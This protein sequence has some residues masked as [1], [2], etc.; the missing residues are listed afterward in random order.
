[1]GN[2]KKAIPFAILALGA[3][4]AALGIWQ[5]EAADVWQKAG[6]VCLECIGIG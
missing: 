1:M 6:T 2:L 4:L 5:G 3:V